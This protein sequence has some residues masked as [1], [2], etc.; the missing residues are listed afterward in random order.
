MHSPPEQSL[1]DTRATGTNVS[2]YIDHWHRHYWMQVILAQLS[3]DTRATG[4]NVGGYMD[5]W[6][7]YY[8]IQVTMAQSPIDTYSTGTVG[9]RYEPLAQPLMAI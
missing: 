7:R 3:M 8:W 9:N 2:G 4:T 6:H 5:H 1:I